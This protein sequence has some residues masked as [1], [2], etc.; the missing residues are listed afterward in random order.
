MAIMNEAIGGRAALD[1]AV[2]RFQE[3]VLADPELAGYFDGMD[4]RRIL[5]RQM[6]LLAFM[7]GAPAQSATGQRPS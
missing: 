7:A 3:R 6:A 2:E 1:A 5:A 4:M